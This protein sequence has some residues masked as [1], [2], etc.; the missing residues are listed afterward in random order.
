MGCLDACAPSLTPLVLGTC[1]QQFLKG[2]IRALAFLKCNAS[3]DDVSGG[4]TDVQAWEDLVLSSDLVFTGSL[5]GSKPKG[6]ATKLRTQSCA[7]EVVTARVQTL[8]FRDF[9]AD[10]DN[11]TQYD[12]W[13]S[14][15]NNYSTLQLLYITCEGYVY[16]PFDNGS[17]SIDV[18]DVRNETSEEPVFMDGSI[19]ISKL[20]LT[21]PVLVAGILSI[22]P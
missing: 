8:S 18:D 14:I 2:G 10:L 12:F 9:N 7:P 6:S 21:K 4:I 17:W 1:T 15:Q 22:L 13:N 20:T 3:F 5:I 11:L 16:G 19:S